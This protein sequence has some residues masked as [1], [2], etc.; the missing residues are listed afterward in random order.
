MSREKIVITGIRAVTPN[1]NNVDE[2][3][4]NLTLGVSGI[5]P[6]TYFDSSNHRVKIAGELNNF[7]PESI[8]DMSAAK[9][10]A[11]INPASPPFNSCRMK[12]GKA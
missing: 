3:W 1:G 12:C 4:S 7:S 9:M 2:Y 10:A 5:G 8:L 6:I 11:I